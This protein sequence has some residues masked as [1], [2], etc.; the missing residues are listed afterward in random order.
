MALTWKQYVLTKLAEECA[1]VAQRALKQQQFGKDESQPGQTETNA[2]RLRYEINDLK[3]IV[4][5]LEDLGEIE[6]TSTAQFSEHFNRKVEKLLKY[7]GYSR[8]LGFVEDV[9]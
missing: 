6:H 1:E 5:L 3:S 2:D 9:K 4:I 8:Q 7:S